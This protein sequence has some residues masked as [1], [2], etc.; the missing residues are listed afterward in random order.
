MS[1]RASGTLFFIPSNDTSIYFI[2]TG[3]VF[4]LA[5]WL[6][7]AP[8]LGYAGNWTK[9]AEDAADFSMWMGANLPNGLGALFAES[10]AITDGGQTDFY[11]FYSYTWQAKDSPV[12]LGVQ[13]EFVNKDGI[14]GP[15]IGI[16]KGAWHFE[17]QFFRPLKDENLN[18]FRL[19]TFL[20]F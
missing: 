2:Y 20:N 16:S 15:H 8:Q 4:N 9:D 11:G 12:N 19:S 6:W 1:W 14:A 7:V 5:D 10:E 17:V 13:A 18:I 3:P